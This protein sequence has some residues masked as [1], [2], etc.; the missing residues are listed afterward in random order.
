MNNPCTALIM[1]TMNDGTRRSVSIRSTGY[2]V[3]RHQQRWIDKGA[4][5]VTVVLWSTSTG[6]E[7]CSDTAHSPAEI[8]RIKSIVDA[9]NA[10]I[11]A[12]GCDYVGTRGQPCFSLPLACTGR[13]VTDDFGNATHWRTTA[14]DD[15]ERFHGFSGAHDAY[16]HRGFMI[17]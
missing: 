5:S 11:A 12:T 14:R 16:S 1:A 6:R 7:I 15:A 4:K 9:E 13:V 3:D 10:V 17:I 2:G 8:A